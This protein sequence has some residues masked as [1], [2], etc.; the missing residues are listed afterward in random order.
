MYNW[1]CVSGCVVNVV[2]VSKVCIPAGPSAE[3]ASLP[4]PLYFGGR[5]SLA[6][7][8][9]NCDKQIDQFVEAGDQE[10]LNIPA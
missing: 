2:I 10:T 4:S 1:R 5:L 7:F 9:V 8:P 6:R 3:Q